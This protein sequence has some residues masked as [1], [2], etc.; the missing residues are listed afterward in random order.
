MKELNP[1]Q[2][3]CTQLDHVKQYIDKHD[4]MYIELL[5]Y[6]QKILE[7]SLPLKMDNGD[8]NSYTGYR[9]Q[10]CDVRGPTKGGIR[11]HPNVDLDEVKALAAWMSMKTAVMNIP[12]GGAK[13]G[14]RI[15]PKKLDIEELE[16]LS[17]RYASAI[18]PIIGPEKDIPAPDVYTTPQIMA[19]MTDTY[20][21]MKGG[22]IS[23][24]FTG[25]P[26][27]FGGSHGRNEATARGLFFCVLHTCEKL[28][29]SISDTCSAIQGY[30]N[31]GLHSH[32]FIQEAGSK[33][34]AVSDSK[35]AIIN[36]KGLD[37]KEVFQFKM[38]NDKKSVV[39]F[40]KAETITNEELLELKVDILVPAA[41]ENAITS[42]NA[43]KI[44]ASIIPEAA[45]GP[46]TPEA[47]VILHRNG[48][49]VI[50]DILAN[51]GGV[52]VSYFEWVQNRNGDHWAE[53]I[54][55][56]KLQHW[57]KTAFQSVW[58]EKVKHDIDMRTA[59]YIVAVTRLVNGY[60][61]RGIWP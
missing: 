42:K 22:T 53:D 10:H 5:K 20:S 25:K 46:C 19:W 55:D 8:I 40:P 31:A 45:N 23:S 37:W 16:R 36:E 26:L 61:V 11:F 41:L 56:Q 12:F 3:F 44:Q 47:D 27:E 32:K 50:P 59:A 49:L 4:H 38:N 34:I 54:V 58:D 15:N 6:P 30:G 13:G 18:A 29:I 2:N 21:M 28:N 1:F 35:G 39:G 52:T 14:I 7:V 9:V 51:G 33:V 60:K 43:E 17:R 48:K 24:A 57:M